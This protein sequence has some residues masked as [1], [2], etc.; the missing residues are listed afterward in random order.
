MLPADARRIFL[1]QAIRAFVYGLGSVLIGVTLAD[2]GLSGVEVGLVI[3]ALVAGT[4]MVSVLLARY[5]D[6]AGRLRCYSGLFVVMGIAGTV[7][8]LTNSVWLL[9]LAALTGTLST[10]VVESGPFT[11][12]EQAMLPSASEGHDPTRLFGHYNTIATLAGSLGALA[13]VGTRFSNVEPQRFLLAYPPVALAAIVVAAGLSRTVDSKGPSSTRRRPSL[14]KSRG[15]VARMSALFALDSFGGG[16]VT[17]AFLAYW[18]TERWGSSPAT[19]GIMF[20]AIGL[21]QAASFQLAVRLAGRIGLLNTMVF[22]HLPSNLLLALIPFAPSQRAAIALV[23]GRFALSQ[24]DVPTRQAYVVAVVDPEERTAAASYTNTARYVVRPVGPLVSG[25]ILAVSLSAPFVIAGV[26]KSA[27]DAG[28]YALF[29]NV[30]LSGNRVRALDLEVPD[31][32][33]PAPDQ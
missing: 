17:Q 2:L 30:R 4:A 27:Y 8:A 19:L 7:F 11:S 25:P 6:R 16:F 20:F 23:F 15:I 33:D 5:G 24:M 28:L 14:E 29:R 22:T 12:L 21:L 9:I 3:S 1:V 32:A 18:F 31:P 13:A 26:L 10:E